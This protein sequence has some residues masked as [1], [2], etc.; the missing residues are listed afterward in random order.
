MY[1]EL[2]HFLNIAFCVF[3]L[4]LSLSLCLSRV[5]CVSPSSPLNLRFLLC[6]SVFILASA[7]YFLHGIRVRG[8][9]TSLQPT[10]LEEETD[11]EEQEEQEERWIEA[12][13][14]RFQQRSSTEPTTRLGLTRCTSTCSGTATG[15]MSKELMTW[16]PNRHTETSGVGAIGEQGI[17]LL[18]VM[19]GRAAVELCS[20]CADTKGCVGKS[21]E[22]FRREHNS[23][24]ASAPTG[25][26]QPTTTRFVGGGLHL[27]DQEHL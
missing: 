11:E 22:G 18:C 14:G 5:Y 19:C 6:H 21:E 27:K 17:I 25:V 4:S 24:E 23:Q 2:E 8:L 16:H 1:I 3:S 20:G 12:W 7:R 15:V 13:R 26:E 10:Q 9:R